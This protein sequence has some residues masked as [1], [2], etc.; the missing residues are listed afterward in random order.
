M[1]KIL[2]SL[3]SV[4]AL[5]A[6]VAC[7]GSNSTP[8]P[9][10]PSTGN[11]VGFTNAN[12]KGTYVFSGNGVNS[13]N[14]NFDLVGVFT[15]DGNGNITSGYHNVYAD[16]VSPVLEPVTGTYSVNTDGRGQVI[17]NGSSGQAI[18]RFVMQSPSS[19]SF[20]QFSPGADDTGLMKLQSAVSSPSGT[21]IVR[22]QGEDSVGNPYG[23]IGG[24]TIAGTSITG[25]IDQ[26]DAG[27]L[28]PSLP[29]SG[30]L[31]APDSTGRGTLQL[32]F[33]G[34]PHS[35][36]YY[37]V[38]A[39]EIVIAGSDGYTIHGYADLQTTL[40]GL[41][42][43]QIF[44]LTGVGTS[45]NLS[46]T[47][48][49]TLTGGAVTNAV[50][51]YLIGSNTAG[52]YFGGINGVS[53][54]GTYATGASGRWTA[55][56]GGSLASNLIG[57]QVS[58]QQSL[59]LAWNGSSTI[60]ETG[61]MRAQNTSITTASITGPYSASLSGFNYNVSGY[62]ELGGNFDA[63]GGSLDG[64]FDSQTPG[65]Y[66]TDIASSGNYSIASNGRSPNGNVAGVSVVIYTVDAS[67]AY[68]I[69]S[70]PTRIY[71]GKLLAQ[72]P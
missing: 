24:L 33:A 19:A 63:S 1:R 2:L 35:Y 71:Q 67:T 36:V 13:S 66:N 31:T 64:T 39:S 40:S 34:A 44:S 43:D 53:F 18:Y 5:A 37:F 22:L 45:G 61:T 8:V 15:A 10:N 59:V 25:T 6:L 28:A 11:D 72:Q 47:G 20:F 57:W 12:L 26:N 46:E 29:A 55:T 69:S 42:G 30:S 32:T 4:V 62:V 7:G 65:Y 70:D 50:E 14:Y 54:G 58:P 52:S 21:Y 49:F 3:I 9:S 38:S 23:A 48:R 56:V 16:A 68:L 17:L 51:D 41:S 60:V 27:T